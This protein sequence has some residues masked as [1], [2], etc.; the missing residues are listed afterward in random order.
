MSF[1]WSSLF[2]PFCFL[3]LQYPPFCCPFPNRFFIIFFSHRCGTK[4]KNVHF[5]QFHD[6]VYKPAHARRHSSRDHS[7]TV[8]K[9]TRRFL[10]FPPI[11]LSYSIK[12]RIWTIAKRA[13]IFLCV[14]VFSFPSF[15]FQHVP[16]IFLLPH[17][18]KFDF[19]FLD[20][21][22]CRSGSLQIE[23]GNH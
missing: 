13:V 14:R 6:L 5:H 23:H 9:T 22:M 7:D 3:L 15:P 19:F 16:H 17:L 8:G 11:L 18:F 10:S 12:D 1:S 2:P 21:P 20:P 4:K